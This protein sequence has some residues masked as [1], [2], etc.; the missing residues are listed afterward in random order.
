MQEN[1]YNQ[2]TPKKD[3]NKSLGRKTNEN[4][5]FYFSSAIK[6]FDPETGKV[7]VQKRCE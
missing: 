6:I 3:Q 7:I 4:Y 5:G 2:P 1:K